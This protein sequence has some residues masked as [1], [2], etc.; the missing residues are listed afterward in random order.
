MNTT[1]KKGGKAGLAIPVGP[2]LIP[3]SLITSLIFFM[4]LLVFLRYSFNYN[5]PGKFMEA[6]FSLE[7]YRRFFADSYYLG[8]LQRTISTALIATLLTLALAF[9]VAYY[10]SRAGVRIKSLMVILLVFPM[11]TGGVIRSMGWI[12]LLSEAG[13]INR[14]FLGIGLINMPLKMLYTDWAVIIVIATIEIPMMTITL[15]AVLE[16]IHP[17]IEAAARNLGAN[18]LRIFRKITLPLAMPGILAGTLLVFV[19]SMNT[20]TTSRMIGGPRLPMMAP[21][22]YSELTDGLNWPFSAAIAM[23]L[24]ILTLGI[25]YA[26][27]HVLERRYIK[28]LHLN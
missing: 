25:T 3:A 24:L 8:I 26:Y 16:S 15:E 1:L 9:P 13:L 20:Y 2:L 10:M 5:V 17:D 27:S 12:G 22:L 18:T 14:I 7:N 28:A 21:A 11:M 19:Q 23:I 6:A 4:P